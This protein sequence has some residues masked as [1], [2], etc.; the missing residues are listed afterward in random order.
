MARIAAEMLMV[1]D[2]AVKKPEQE[3]NDM[4]GQATTGPAGEMDLGVAF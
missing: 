2:A 1:S 4:P 3:Q